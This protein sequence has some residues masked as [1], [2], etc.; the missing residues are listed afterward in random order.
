[1][2]PVN[3]VVTSEHRRRVYLVWCLN[4]HGHLDLEVQIIYHINTL[5]DNI[6]IPVLMNNMISDSAEVGIIKI[7]LGIFCTLCVGSWQSES[8]HQ[9]QNPAKCIY[10]IVKTITKNVPDRSG[11]PT[12][13]WMLCIMYV[14]FF[15]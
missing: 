1:M 6:Q 15:K 11:A 8:H 2:P 14:F 12:S 4:L 13:T 5:E 7:V 10:N 9:H 3:S